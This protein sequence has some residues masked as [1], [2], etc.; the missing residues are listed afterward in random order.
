M[1]VSKEHQEEVARLKEEH[2]AEMD[3][4]ISA[5]AEAATLSVENRLR[6]A[7]AGFEKERPE[8][9]KEIAAREKSFEEAREKMAAEL[10]N[11]RSYAEEL[12]FKMQELE[13]ELARVR[14]DSAAEFL[15][16]ITE[17]D[18]KIAS[19]E[20]KYKARHAKLEEDARQSVAELTASY[21]AKIK[22][23][24]ELLKAKEKLIQDSEEFWSRKQ[25]EVDKAHSDFNLRINKFNE[26]L[27]AQKQELGEKE[28]E[29]NDYRLKLEK[30]Y[31]AKNAEME[32]MKA[33]LTRAII[34]YKNRK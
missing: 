32:K 28:T 27:F 15:G 34:D 12:D 30:E 25:T 13:K 6:L 20:G 5:A 9:K 2:A 26:E 18:E 3:A 23:M 1:Q 22:D 7:D 33:E 31:A 21:D 24:E 19:L 17:Q 16:R 4:K 14:Q 10:G 8:H 29:L 11:A